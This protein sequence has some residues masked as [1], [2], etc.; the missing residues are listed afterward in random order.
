LD[1]NVIT[2]RIEFVTVLST[3]LPLLCS[4]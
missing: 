1:S 4:S 2:P 3:A